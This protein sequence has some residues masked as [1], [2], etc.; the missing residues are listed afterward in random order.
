M[1][2]CE[3]LVQTSGN[4]VFIALKKESAGKPLPLLPMHAMSIDPGELV[5]VLKLIP[6]SYVVLCGEVDLCSSILGSLEDVAGSMPV[7]LLEA[8]A[9]RSEAV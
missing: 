4:V 1:K 7:Y 9:V 3:R 2:E 6:D 8:A 5:D